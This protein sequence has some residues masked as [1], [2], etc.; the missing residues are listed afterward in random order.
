MKKTIGIIIGLILLINVSASICSGVP[1]GEK[2]IKVYG[3]IYIDSEPVENADVS[4]KNLDKGYEVSTTT[5]SD[6]YY[7]VY[8]NG[9]NNDEMR[10]EVEFDEVDDDREFEIKDGKHNYEFNFDFESTPVRK[11]YHK[12]VNLVFGLHWGIWEWVVLIFI[13]LLILCMVKKVFFNGRNG[14][15]HYN[16]NRRGYKR[17]D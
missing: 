9:K 17:Y 16:N 14:H 5:N 2:T 3:N 6:G 12:L 10:V 7:E 8:I 11:T 1:D 4:V 15:Y 13:I